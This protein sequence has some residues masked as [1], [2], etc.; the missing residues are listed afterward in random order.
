MS[1][2]AGLLRRVGRTHEAAPLTARLNA[3]GYRAAV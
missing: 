2:R 1:E 3:L